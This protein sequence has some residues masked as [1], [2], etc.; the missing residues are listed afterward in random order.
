M[1]GGS[2]GMGIARA[3]AFARTDGHSRYHTAVKL[4]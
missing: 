3:K 4:R 2:L 1:D